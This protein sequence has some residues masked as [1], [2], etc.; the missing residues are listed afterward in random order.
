[1]FIVSVLLSQE[2]LKQ[3][4]IDDSTEFDEHTV[5]EQVRKLH[6]EFTAEDAEAFLAYLSVKQKRSEV[7][8]RLADA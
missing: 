7:F 4:G 5:T 1:M 8:K 3:L 2:V 6:P